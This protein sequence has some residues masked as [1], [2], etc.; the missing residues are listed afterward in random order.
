VPCG[1]PAFVHKRIYSRAAGRRFRRACARGSAPCLPLHAELHG[2]AFSVKGA[3]RGH[4]GILPPRGGDGG[5]GEGE[6]ARVA[7]LRPQ[8]TRRGSAHSREAPSFRPGGDPATAILLLRPLMVCCP[9]SDPLQRHKEFDNTDGRCA[10]RSARQTHGELR[11]THTRWRCCSRWTTRRREEFTWRARRA[12]EV[13][14][15]AP[16]QTSDAMQCNAYDNKCTPAELDH[17][18]RAQHL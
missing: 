4:A 15:G 1:S 18:L 3:R 11:P 5:G 13:G 10:R 14:V 12:R 16:L 9:T 7:S 17:G 2:S 6:G 8:S